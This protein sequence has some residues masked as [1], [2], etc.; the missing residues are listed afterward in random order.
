MNP[1][2]NCVGTD[3]LTFEIEPLFYSAI[4]ICKPCPAKLWCLQRVDPARNLYD[5]VVGGHA[6]KDGV[7]QDQLSDPDNDPILGT[8]LR[9]RVEHRAVYIDETAVAGFI[10]GSLDYTELTVHER[11]E[12]AVRLVQAGTPINQAIADT[13]VSGKT[14]AKLL[15]ERRYS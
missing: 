8:Y 9:S 1:K 10:S 6:W 12:A 11:R 2:P 7:A 15:Q 14:I 5:G 4:E 13:H 3:P